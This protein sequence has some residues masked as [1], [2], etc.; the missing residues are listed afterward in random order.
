MPKPKGVVAQK[1][2]DAQANDTPS[3]ATGDI[4]AETAEASEDQAEP[5]AKAPKAK[6][7]KDFSEKGQKSKGKERNN[8]F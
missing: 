4:A 7:A 2:D 8:V 6:K 1:K 3:E 5:K